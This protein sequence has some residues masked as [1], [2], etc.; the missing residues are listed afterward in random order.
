M[1]DDFA[2]T[3][4]T[5][6]YP[7]Y[8]SYAKDRPDL[9]LAA[10]W[11]HARR[12]FY[13]AVEQTPGLANWMLHQI[14]LLYQVEAPLRETQAGATLRQRERACASGMIIKRIHRVL[15]AKR[16]AHR[17][18]LLITKAINYTLGLWKQLECF[19][20]DGRL[21]IDNNLV[22]NAIRPT[23][24]G[25]TN[26]LFY[27]APESGQR[28]AIIYTIIENCKRLGVPPQEYLH[29]VLSRL[30]AMTNQQTHELT[31]ANWAAQREV[32]VA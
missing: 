8:L 12:Y 11:A 25:K 13:E 31:P 2:G 7:V 27:G 14:G 17:P 3:I 15:Q 9:V 22:E 6:G 29:D 19:L 23:A 24:I 16:R 1:L 4:Q 28:S 10:C 32:Q 26:Y 30:P 18:E 5:D 21:E 20:E